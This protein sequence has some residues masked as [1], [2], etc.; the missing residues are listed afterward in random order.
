MSKFFKADK[1]AVLLLIMFFLFSFV[2]CVIAYDDEDEEAGEE[3][4]ELIS[5][6]EYTDISEQYKP[7][8]DKKS[9][10]WYLHYA[11]ASEVLETLTSIFDIEIDNNEIVLVESKADN[12]IIVRI[13]SDENISLHRECLD[14]IRQLDLRNS[15]VLIDV[16]IAQIKLKQGDTLGIEWQY[17]GANTLNQ[18]GLTSGMIIDHDR[19]QNTAKQNQENGFKFSLSKSNKIKAFIQGLI[20]DDKIKVLSSPHIIAT[21]NKK[22]SF[23]IQEVVPI[24]KSVEVQ[25]GGSVSTEID[26]FE[27]GIVLEVTPRI[28]KGDNVTLQINQRIDEVDYD[29]IEKQAQKTLRVINTRLTLD[30]HQTIVLGGFIKDTNRKFDE[31]IPI[32]SSLPGIGNLFN[33]KEYKTEK[34]ELVV[35]LTPRIINT[36]LDSDNARDLVK[37]RLKHREKIDEYLA[38]MTRV[39]PELEKNA[40]MFIDQ[41]ACGWHYFADS[42]ILP[43]LIKDSPTT[44]NTDNLLSHKR[45]NDTMTYTAPFGYGPVVSKKDLYNTKIENNSAYV[46]LQVLDH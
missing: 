20:D 33:R 34:T 39:K 8:A 7:S 5:E 35:F 22:A 44:V 29:P 28:S 26:N 10:I 16:M 19:V 23:K 31:K 21:T 37:K 11:K 27:A 25:A 12:A 41:G 13:K 36:D 42:K 32:L 15:Q 18:P 17:G 3:K 24:I 40:E 9:F 30:N 4:K 1:F 14:I 45:K 6:Q 43:E 2:T 38:K 46:R